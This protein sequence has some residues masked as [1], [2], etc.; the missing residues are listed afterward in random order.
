MSPYSIRSR[1]IAAIILCSS[2]ALAQEV[3]PP[4][5][6]ATKIDFRWGVKVPMRDGV[7]LGATLYTPKNS[8][9]PTPCL[10]SITPYT[11]QGLHDRGVYFAAHGLPFLAI[12]SRGRGNSEGVFRP[13]I[14]E[15]QDGYDAVEW[16]AK[17]TYC[18]GKVAMWGGSYVGYDQWAT[19]KERPPHLA[20][21]VPVASV[22]PGL[23]FPMFNNVPYPYIMQ[24]LTLVSGHAGQD[25]IFDDSSFW[26]ATDRHWYESGTPF[27]Q[28]DRLLGNPSPTFQEWVAHPHPDAYWDAYTPSTSQYAQL[29]IPILTIT[30]SHD[31]DQP[32]ALAYY[33][34]HM[35]HGSSATQAKHY[36]IIGPWDHPG[37]RRPKTE[38]A[39]LTVGS[40][41]LV[42]LPQLHLQWYAWTMQGGPK[43]EFLQKRVA[44]Y[45]MGADRWRYA[46]SLEAVTA[47]HQSLWLDSAVNA[48]DVF[49]SGSLQQA[50]GKGAADHYIYDPRDVS[51]TEF[52]PLPKEGP[53]VDQRRTYA[54]SGKQLVYHSDPFESDTEISGFFRFSAW[55]GIDQ[56]D[57]DFAVDIYEI[58]VNGSSTYL[59]GDLMRARYREDFR[60]PR[61]VQTTAPL[62]YDFERFTFVSRQIRKRTRLRLTLRPINF[63]T[64]QKNYNSGKTVA[65]ESMA[66]A[67]PVTVRLFH[68]ARHPSVLY[69]PIGQP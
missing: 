51:D 26:I 46:D 48:T 33:Q 1:W 61:L 67:R 43:P 64:V 65:E 53:L 6:D 3:A 2:S 21:I 29:E 45:V 60:S 63:Y 56:P 32:G 34:Q 40:A 17:Q 50:R 14:Q 47:R 18:N 52:T 8:T 5:P 39:G 23:D 62:Q 15:A 59:T 66:D 7:H 44:Y 42:D 4:P 68:D 41:S 57:T 22:Y 20:T 54:A 9:T 31:G 37:T 36:L 28:L 13:F 30:G 12:D 55:I 19:A 49:R 27:V 25:A 35:T 10:L 24:W 11:A 69:V 38:F 16:L 58:A